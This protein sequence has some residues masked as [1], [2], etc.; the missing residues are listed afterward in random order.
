LSTLFYVTDTFSV[1]HYTA[2]T[3]ISHFFALVCVFIQSN[4]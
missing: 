3:V 2:V 1:I 4:A